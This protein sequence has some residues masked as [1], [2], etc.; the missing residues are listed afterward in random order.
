MGSKKAVKSVLKQH[1]KTVSRMSSVS[2]VKG[3]NTM[4]THNY[5]QCIALPQ[6]VK[7]QWTKKNDGDK[8]F[9]GKQFMHYPNGTVFLHVEML[10]N[11]QVNY[12]PKECLLETAFMSPQ[13][14]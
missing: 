3:H 2:K 14:Q 5:I 10:V 6:K 8:I 12:C 13:G 9:H 1:T 11:T 4:H 7:F